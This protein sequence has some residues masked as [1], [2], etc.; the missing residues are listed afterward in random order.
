MG[1]S[2]VCNPIPFIE[3]ADQ[4]QVRWTAQNNT[5]IICCH[6]CIYSKG[7]VVRQ[8]QAFF[9]TPRTVTK[10]LCIVQVLELAEKPLKYVM[11]LSKRASEEK[12]S[13]RSEQ[14]DQFPYSTVTITGQD[15]DPSSSST[16]ASEL[17]Q[18]HAI[19]HGNLQ[20]NP[21]L[22]R[23]LQEMTRV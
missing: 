16:T 1:S 9:G 3:M 10:I 2:F 19:L 20:L 13:T 14:R 11:D 22:H 17:S 23:C 12:A 21:L 18:L 7:S 6:V 4:L 5:A 8:P 15:L